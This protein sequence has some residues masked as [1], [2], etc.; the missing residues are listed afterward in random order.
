MQLTLQARLLPTEEQ[1]QLLAATQRQYVQLCNYMSV[2]VHE[3]RITNPHSIYYAFNRD[4]RFMFPELPSALHTCA[5]AKVAGAYRSRI[6]N[7]KR[8]KQNGKRTKSMIQPNRF[9]PNT[10]VDYSKLTYSVCKF[11]RVDLTNARYKTESSK[12]GSRYTTMKFSIATIAG[13]IKIDALVPNAVFFKHVG[14]WKQATLV[15]RKATKTWYF[16]IAITTKE[17]EPQP[18]SKYIGVD[19][20]ISN[21]ATTSD[22]AII[23]GDV[24]DD[25]RMKHYDHVRKLQKRN[26]RSAKRRLSKIRRRMSNFIRTTNHTISKLIVKAAQRSGSCIVLEHIKYLH[27]SLK[28]RKPQRIRMF[29][30]SYAQ[31]RDFICYKAKI[32]GIKIILVDPKYSS[33]KCCECGHIERANRHGEKFQCK[34]CGHTDHADINAA[35]NLAVLGM[36]VDHYQNTGIAIPAYS[37]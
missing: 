31:L 25:K 18:Y 23:S 20:G 15:Y 22:G 30:W 9:N 12:L 6:A 16:H 27:E 29:G 17:L 34:Q 14:P 28:A 32:L 1:A 5:R 33:Q 8:R 37:K 26:T 36:I 7:F 10:S 24:I 35:M 11:D 4:L 21:I 3:T 2:L 19:L 13:R